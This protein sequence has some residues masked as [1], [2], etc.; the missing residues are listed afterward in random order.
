TVE[1]DLLGDEAVVIKSTAKV[2]GNA[3]GPR[4]I[5]EDGAQFKGQVETVAVHSPKT[6]AAPE[7]SRGL[8]KY[9]EQAAG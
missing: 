1:G 4:I 9:A 5:I 3:R 2:S 8:P 6:E 7:E